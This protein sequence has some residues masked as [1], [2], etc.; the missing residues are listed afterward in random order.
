M[1]HKSKTR[2][3][4]DDVVY[5]D[6]RFAKTKQCVCQKFVLTFWYLWQKITY[7]IMG[8]VWFLFPLSYHTLTTTFCAD[9]F[10][11]QKKYCAKS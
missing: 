8:L 11:F 7:N 2:G 1:C 10:S 9:Y 4:R 3:V 5:C 6:T